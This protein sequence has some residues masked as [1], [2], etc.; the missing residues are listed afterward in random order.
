MQM[1]NLP[2]LLETIEALVSTYQSARP[3]E[4][5][6]RAGIT[7]AEVEEILEFGV[8]PPDGPSS[9]QR[10]ALFAIG[11]TLGAIGGFKLMKQVYDAYEE[12]Y[13]HRHAATLSAR[14]DTA[15]G[16]WYD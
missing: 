3:R 1:D 14:W 15:A 13:G 4:Q 8:Y 5:K 10:R 11:E 12:K 16:V 9:I 7:K 6:M 2:R